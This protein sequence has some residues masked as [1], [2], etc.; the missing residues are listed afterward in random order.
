MNNK[1]NEIE[2]QINDELNNIG[3][4]DLVQNIRKLLDEANAIIEKNNELN[5]V[6]KNLSAEDQ[7]KNEVQ[8]M[9]RY[10]CII[11]R[12]RI[13]D[14]MIRNG[15]SWKEYVTINKIEVPDEI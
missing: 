8:A 3:N 11:M 5:N 14:W 15:Y 6:I 7:K 13:A 4:K 9:R 1:I 2:E 10:G 12:E